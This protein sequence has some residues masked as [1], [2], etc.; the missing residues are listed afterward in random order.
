MRLFSLIAALTMAATA[1]HAASSDDPDWPCQQRRIDTLSLG[2]V[3]S[4]PA[5]DEA[6]EKLAKTQ[7]IRE[8]AQFLEQRRTPMQDAEAMI[9]NFAVKATP[10]EMTALYLATFERLDHARSAII[11]G[12]IRYAKKQEALD[13]RI[14]SRRAEMARLMAEAKPDYDRID[15]LEEQLDWD[16]RVFQDRQQSLTYVCETPVILEKRAFALGRAVMGQMPR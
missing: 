12:I 2:Q 5:P 15:T 7:R 4:G 14:D 3:W 8:L 13:E 11:A 1:G 16:I 6:V 9:A 10:Q